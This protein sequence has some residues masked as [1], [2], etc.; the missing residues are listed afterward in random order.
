MPI[1]EIP[2]DLVPENSFLDQIPKAPTGCYAHL[3]VVRET[4]SF[5]FFK[6]MVRSTLPRSRAACKMAIRSFASPCSSENRVHQSDL[7]DVNC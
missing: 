5:L 7:P 4:E 1:I 6:Q 2:T 3:I